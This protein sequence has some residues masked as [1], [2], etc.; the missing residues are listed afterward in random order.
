VP[1]RHAG[2]APCFP[3]DRNGYRTM[4][5]T[6]DRI[7]AYR[8]F[9]GAKAQLAPSSGIDID[10]GDIHPVLKPHQRDAVT[11]AVRGGRR[12]I[13][14]SFGLGKSLM[15]LEA[16]RLILATLGSGRGLIVCPLGVRQ[17]FARDARMLGVETTFIR[18]A[19]EASRDG[20]YLT[21]Y[22][23]VRDGKLDP[24]GFD[25]VSLDEAAILRGFGGTK[26][27]RE[28]MRLYEGS[29]AFRFVATATPSPNEYIE[30]LSY[31]AFLD[32][33]DVGQGKAQPLD[34]KILT[35]GGWTTM[36][37]IRP[38]DQVI[39]GDGTP[40]R[41]LGVY[42]QGERPIYRVTFSDG[43]STEADGE[44]LWLTT[45]QYERNNQ[46]RH[47]QLHPRSE[48]EFA[49]VK[50]TA[51]IVATLHGPHHGKN[52]RIP[53]VGPVQFTEQP[54]AIDPWLLGA[55]LGDGGLRPTSV[56]LTTADE[57]IIKAAE[58]ALPPGLILRKKPQA[59][60]DYTVTSAGRKGGN[61]LGSNTLL[62]ALRGYGLLGKR[63][64]EKRVPPA[65][66]TNSVHVRLA[67]LRGLMDTDGTIG[68]D[69]TMQSF[70]TSS[71]GLAQDVA[72]LVRSLGGTASIRRR[73]TPG[74]DSHH[75]AIQ[76]PDALNPF[77]LPRKAILVRAWTK[78]PPR[79]Y[80]VNVE[81]VGVKAAQCIAVEHPDRLYVTDDF[82]VTHNTRFFKRDS[83]HADR[84]TLHSHMEDEFFSWLA[85]WALFLQKPS[86]IGHPDDGYDL[87][88]LDI[89]WHEVPSPMAPYFGEGQHRD[90]Q[91]FM[92]RDASFG[93]TD[94]A[95]EKRISMDARIAETA[96]IVAAAP[97]DHFLLW[98][99]LEDERRAIEAAVPDAVTVWGSQDLDERE[100]RITGFSDGEFRI[101]A[102]KP[103]IAGSGCNFQ[104][105]CHR[106]VFTGIGFKFSDF[107]QAIHRIHRF[108]QTEP[109][110][111]DIIYSEAERGIRAQLERKWK[112]HDE[113]TARMG[114]LIRGRG[115]AREALASVSRT[116]GVHR[117]EVKGDG[118]LLVNNDAV[119]E[120][121]AMPDASAGLI[122]TSIPF[123][124]QYEYTPCYDEQTQVLTRRGWLYFGELLGDDMLATVNQE[125]LALE[126]QVPSEIVWR[127]YQGPMLHFRQ[128]SSFDLKVTP[129][130]KMFVDTRVGNRRTGR[131][132]RAFRLVRADEMARSF[133]P[134]KW[135]MAATV[136]PGTGAYPDRIE[137]PQC[138]QRRMPH[139]RTITDIA[140]AD[141][142]R[143][144]GWYLSEGHCD[145]GSTVGKRGRIA[146]S[147]S[148]THPE[149]RREII[150][151]F[152]RIGLPVNA[153]HRTNI[154]AWNIS[155]A[156][157]LREQF[158]TGSCKKSIPRW[159]KDLHPDLLCILR[160]T[161]MKGDGSATGYA[162]TSYSERLRDD[163]QEICLLT[164]WRT[165]VTGNIVRIGQQN[166]FPE[167]REAP[168]KSEYRGM[169]G[170]ATVPNHTL[171]VRRNGSAVISGNSYNDFGHTE[172]NAHFWQQ[173]DYLT[174]ELLRVLAPGRIACIHV[175]DRIAPGGLTGLG[176]Q[177]LQ[178]FHAE[179]IQHYMG[180]GFAFMAMITVVTDV[181]RENNQTYRLGWTEQCKDG[182]KMGSGVPEYVLVFRKPP[183]DSATSYADAPVVK[184]KADY[185]RARWQTDAHGF[186]RSDGNRPLLPDELDGIA[187]KDMFRK[188]RDHYLNAVYDYEAHVRAAERLE[189]KGRLP[190]GFMLLQPPS[191]HDQ[192]WTDV[193][194]MRTLNMLQERKGQQFHLCPLQWDIVDRLITRYSNEGDTV[195]DPFGG[196]MTVPYCAVKLGRHGTGIELNTRYFLDGAAYVKAAADEASA[197]ALFDLE[198]S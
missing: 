85:S 133:A 143:L 156:A 91:G 169:I 55:L 19:A 71:P 78:Y 167:V 81:P 198:A 164:G 63:S 193:A 79:R 108:L 99:D 46:R 151:L 162:Y 154:V 61:G 182:T 180:H 192:V 183:S 119:E 23:S 75:V 104:R 125:S 90:G 88:P 68:R 83:E 57:W 39:A 5:T 174:P 128:R 13:F 70:A 124:T 43:S 190:S 93:V 102:T 196:L 64:H 8:E 130:H 142:M 109:V 98:H 136:A 115:L 72:A 33:L 11:W 141:F 92:F 29:A 96:A 82:V 172:D 18:S 1:S 116:T 135:V 163:M 28:L 25:V 38:G 45:T 188:F 69:G 16:E 113:L 62:T 22:E 12:A 51:E 176:F 50:T 139:S 126:W 76:M 184:R 165:C 111:I 21:N 3:H 134:R 121:M 52:H 185:S 89:R 65:Y 105:H 159:V 59:E 84:L 95:R 2:R 101:L 114:E 7:A 10:P 47:R 6:E 40:T 103:V 177:T 179:A 37:A 49:T 36:G 194:R 149:N 60:Y 197:P 74:R 100:R 173:M 175:K 27:F 170:C 67:V 147:Q 140:V 195:L 168:E 152:E 127:P 129:H 31:A 157:F 191:W 4:S 138:D 118:F 41:V 35:P 137:I 20:I 26:T 123:A 17:E 14:A 144:A 30:L 161:M 66:I 97:D 34:A 120:A 80:I 44:H 53:L 153:K 9:L 107:I 54:V 56:T 73:T 87:P 42:P 117:R 32:I 58:A 148:D 155:L 94:A 145:D 158:G 166:I 112:Q 160:D 181:V 187:H 131:K 189:G 178:P 132:H 186:W 86:D 122:V 171:I 48:L 24:R 15:Q 77:S 110:R 146:I 150:A 106:A